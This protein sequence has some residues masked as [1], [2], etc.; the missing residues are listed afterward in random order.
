VTDSLDKHRWRIFT[1]FDRHDVASLG[2]VIEMQLDSTSFKLPQHILDSLL[3]GRIVGAVASDEFLDNG[4][5]RGWRQ[6][7]VWDTHLN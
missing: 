6:F 7:R 2:L 3:D 5:E 1:I 4:T